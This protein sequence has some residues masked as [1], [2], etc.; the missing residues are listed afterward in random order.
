[1]PPV[2][3]LIV[4][5]DAQMRAML[6]LVVSLA[7]ITAETAP[8]AEAALA[9]VS[10]AVPDAVLI[11]VH[12]RGRDGFSLAAELRARDPGLRLV[13]MSGDV[14]SDEMQARARLLGVQFLSKPFDPPTLLAVLGADGR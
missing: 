1:M 11:D 9:A 5:D 12:L 13:L 4:D 2:R 3:L 14:A 7:A 8:D 6:A 10:R